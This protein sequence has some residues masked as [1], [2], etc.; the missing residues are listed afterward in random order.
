MKDLQQEIAVSVVIVYTNT[1]KLEE[2]K[3]DLELQSIFQ[4]TELIILDNCQNRFSSAASALN[5]GASKAK[6][7]IIVF[8][9][10]DVYLWDSKLLENYYNVL[11]DNPHAILGVAGV[12]QKDHLIYYDFCETKDKVY[13]ER[14]TNGE[15]MQAITLD[16]CLFAM[17][18][19][20]W[21]KLRFDETTCDNWHFYGADICYNN[22]LNG[23]ENMILSAD[24]CHESTGNAYNKSFRHTLKSMIKKYKKTLDKIETTCVNIR[25]NMLMY[26][27]YSIVSKFKEVMKSFNRRKE[28]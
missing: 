23:G 4:S 3:K 28:K 2:A 21:E 8:M 5:Y 27:I 19:S 6:G 14:T 15:L 9:H 24:M 18:K 26:Y 11:Q 7:K 16:E 20:L 10:Q 17:Q 25:C 12:A 13:R 22:L 1:V